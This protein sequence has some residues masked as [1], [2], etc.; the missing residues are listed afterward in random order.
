MSKKKS[1]IKKCYKLW[2]TIEEHTF[3]E[4]TGKETYKDLKQEETRSIG[5]VDT[6][7][8]AIERMNEIGEEFQGDFRSEDNKI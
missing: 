4:K 3:N 8:E 5:D 1:H 7:E 2:I 6:L